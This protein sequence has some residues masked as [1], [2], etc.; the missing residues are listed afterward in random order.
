[1][2]STDDEPDLSL[3]NTNEFFLPGSGLS[4]LLVHGLTGTPYEMRYLGDQLAST[5]ARVLGVKLAGHGGPPEDLAAV[6]HAQ[7]YESVVEG[8]E[9][10]R[11]YGDPNVVVGLSMGA[12]LIARLAIDQPE[13]VA[14]V[15]MLSP[16]FFLPLSSRV[17]LRVLRPARNLADQIFFHKP[18][19]SDIHDDAARRIHPGTRLMPLRAAINLIELSDSVRPRLSELEQPALLIHGRQDHVCPFE[20]NTEFVMGHLGGP[21]KRMVPLEESYHV[22]TVDSEKERVAREVEAFASAFAM[23]HRAAAHGG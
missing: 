22:I 9:R 11:S 20:K 3:I 14:G 7:W 13:A 10:L 15:A 17:L 8:F 4:V 6:T 2:G 1:M 23:P 16:A 18:G 12:V 19:G 21:H 5:G